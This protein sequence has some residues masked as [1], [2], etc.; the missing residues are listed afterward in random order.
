MFIIGYFFPL[1]AQ[2]MCN[3]MP[4][5]LTIF[6]TSMFMMTHIVLFYIEMIQM[7]TLGLKT[8]LWQGM[9]ILECIMFAASIYY[10]IR[11]LYDPRNKF[12]ANHNEVIAKGSDVE[13]HIILCGAFLIFM[14]MIKLLNLLKSYDQFGN[15]VIMTVIAIKSTLVFCVF[16]GLWVFIFSILFI[17]I[18]AKFDG[19]D[20]PG[21]SLKS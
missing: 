1:I 16:L 3:Y 15:F 20:Y 8:Y 18:G 19:G 10:S 14:S 21:L 13:T 12:F 4:V 6:T 9:N 5:Y 2:I 7:K 11:K 17:S